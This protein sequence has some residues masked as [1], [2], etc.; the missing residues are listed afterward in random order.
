MEGPLSVDTEM[1]MGIANEMA[2]LER[3]PPDSA[4]YHPGHGIRR[5]LLGVDISAGELL[6][7][8]QAGCDAVIA[9]HPLGLVDAWQCFRTHVEQMMRAGVPREAAEAAIAERLDLLAV[10]GQ[11]ENFDRLTSLAKLLDM[12]LLNIHQALDEV[13]RRIFQETIDAALEDNP[14]ATLAELAGAMAQLPELLASPTRV[15]IAK[16]E[17]QARA[18]R[19]VMSLGAYTNG[20]YPVASA[21]YQHG[22]DTVAYIH[23]DPADLVRLRAAPRGQLL[24]TGHYA[25]DAVGINRYIARI[26]ELG[27]EVVRV[28][29]AIA[30]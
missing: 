26:E 16:G 25:S 9:H 18:G 8:R 5:V 19:T 1:L 12:P 27:V 24:I 20:G 10:R 4:I 14:E 29:G 7:A 28:S 2:D 22:V 13:G 30:G 23:I 21:Y 17:P 6:Y 11:S 15:L 3:T